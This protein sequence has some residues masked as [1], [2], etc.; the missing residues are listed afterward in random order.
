MARYRL[1]I[2]VVFACAPA[3][4]AAQERLLVKTSGGELTFMIE[5]ANTPELRT[6]GLMHRSNL[7]ASHGMLFDFSRTAPVS[8][9][10][11]NTLIP[12]DMLFIR[13]DGIIANIAERAVPGSLTPI[14]SHGPV[15]SVLEING[16]VSARLGIKA[17]DKVIHRVFEAP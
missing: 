9:W 8:M 16:G 4:A 7:P 12:L 11:K 17:G 13:A 5:I 15:R 1:I 6:I 14:N 3:Y 10:M 2:L